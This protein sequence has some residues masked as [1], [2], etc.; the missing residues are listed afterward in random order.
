MKEALILTVLT[1]LLPA[2]GHDMEN[3][4]NTDKV[5]RLLFEAAS[6]GNLRDIKML[7]DSGVEINTRDEDGRTILHHAAENLNKELV[8][9]LLE[10]GALPDASD[11]EGETPLHL[12]VVSPDTDSRGKREEVARLLLDRGADANSRNRAG[13]TP[14]HCAAKGTSTKMLD[15]LIDGGAALNVT[16]YQGRSPFDLARGSTCSEVELSL[17]QHGAR[18]S[19]YVPLNLREAAYFGKLN[20]VQKFVTAGA[21]INYREGEEL[22]NSS[23]FVWSNNT[24]LHNAASGGFSDI[25]E[26]LLSSG[27]QANLTNR[28]GKTPL[29][30][31][32][33]EQ[34]KQILFSHGAK[35]G[36]ELKSETEE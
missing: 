7:L 3:T 34:V 15:I 33:T 21:N 28:W 5:R 35:T 13:M 10:R 32:Q 27:A 12:L 1:L 14:L 30:Y 19:E 2:C 11:S 29:D 17:H 4:Q 36:K 26:F 16:D 23:G 8:E 9:L 18:A 6:K 20:E 22:K 24:A 31:A 25:V